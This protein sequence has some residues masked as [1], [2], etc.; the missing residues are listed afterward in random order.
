MRAKDIKFGFVCNYVFPFYPE[1]DKR[2]DII[3]CTDNEMTSEDSVPCISNKVVNLA[4]EL[5]KIHSSTASCKEFG[6]SKGIY[7]FCSQCDWYSLYI[8]SISFIYAIV[9]IACSGLKGKVWVKI[10]SVYH[11]PIKSCRKICFFES[12][13]KSINSCF[14]CD[15]VF[16]VLPCC[17]N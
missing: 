2:Q 11:L 9:E 5:R 1:E 6:T 4:V 17:C 15:I 3:V 16:F 7:A 14:Y 12:T 13:R 8:V 10:K